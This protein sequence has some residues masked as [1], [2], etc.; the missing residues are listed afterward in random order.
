MPFPPVN[1]ALARALQAREYNEPTPVQRAVLEAPTD[2]DLLVSAQTGSGKTVAYG[3]ALATTLIGDEERF[4]RPDAPL[5]LVI[6]PT[7]ELAM[8]VHAELGW[9]Y[10]QAGGRVVADW[11]GL[12][13][14]RLLEGRDLAPT[15]DLRRI[16][17]AALRDHLRLPAAAVEAAF[18]GSLAETPLPGLFRP[19]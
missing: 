11:P 3:L 2:R 9:L 19:A 17:K 6:A 14:A 15:L 12:A 7:R 5:A 16:A 13:P 18:P 1:P 8:Q 4:S 10:A